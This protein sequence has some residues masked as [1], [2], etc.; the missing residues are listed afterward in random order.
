MKKSNLL[1]IAAAV[2]T[3]L[4]LVAYDFMLAG[5]FNSGDYKNPYSDFAL[6][7]YKDFDSVDINSSTAVNVKFVQGPFG[8]MLD[9]YAADY[10]K[11]T[12]HGNHLQ[13]DASFEADYRTNAS[14]YMMVV[15]C[16]KLLRVYTGATYQTYSRPYTDTIVRETWNMREVLISGF[17]QDSIK[18]VQDYGST[19]VLDS[20]Q[21][22]LVSSV[23][24]K[25]AGSGSKLVILNT[26]RLENTLLDIRH[27]SKLFIHKAAISQLNYRMADSAQLIVN[28][29]AQHLL[30]NSNSVNQ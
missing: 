16:P 29:D 8:V 23:T 9:N 30:K 5:R 24:G 20:N 7:N 13:I 2:I 4:S 17:K 6:L 26:N 21:F 1:I 10:T 27:R 3:L 15:S 18:I 28:G 22:R 25:S 12:Q 19:V 11:I 14:L